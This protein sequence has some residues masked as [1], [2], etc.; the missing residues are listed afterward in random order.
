MTR[1][2]GAIAVGG[3]ALL[4]LGDTHA[5]SAAEVTIQNETVR[6][7]YE[8]DAGL[9]TLTDLKTGKAFAQQGSLADAHGPAKVAA[10]TD[11]TFGDGQAI[12]V[13]GTDGAQA[14]L[15]VFPKL[16]FALVRGTMRNGGGDAKVLNKVPL[17]TLHLN[18]GKPADQLK[19]FG[20]GG[21]SLPAKNPGSYAWQV[22]AEP[23]S[24]NGVVSAWLTHDR[25]TGVL[26]TPVSNDQVT[27][28]ARGEYG[29]LRLE[30]GSSTD[31]ETLAIGYFDD[32]RLGLESWADAVAKVYSIHLPVQPTGYCTW[33][34]DKHGGAGD[35][36]S[37]AE[38][39]E[40]A[41]KTLKPYG[42]SFVQIDDGWQL[43]NSQGNGPKKNFT[44]HNPKGP[45]PSGMKAAA[46]HIRGLG[47]TAGIWFMPFA[48][49]FNDPW[50]KDHQD[51]FVKNKDGKPY[52]SS[53]GGTSMDMTHPGA[54]EY[55]RTYVRRIT[56]E[57]GYRYIKIDGLYTGT[58]NQQIYVNSGYKEDSLGDAVFAN[59][60]KTNIEAFR[61][62]LKLVREAAGRETFILGCCAPQNMR[63]YAGA[64][65]L[66][67]AMRIGPDNG[68]SWKG[69]FGPSPVFGTR[70][71]FLNGRV[72]YCDPDPGYA[73]ASISL[74][75]VK[76][77]FS[78]MA[79]AGQLNT[80]SDWIPGLTAERLDVMKRTM[81]SHGLP[82]RPVDLF[83]NEPARIWLLTDDRHWPRRDVIALFNWSN[84]DANVD[85]SLERIGLP[86]NVEYVG[87]DFWANELVS[88]IKGQLKCTMPG[89]SCRVLAVR[90]VADHPQLI[91]TSRHVTQGIVDVLEETWD[92]SSSMLSGR[93]K[94]VGADAYELRL[95]TAGKG[96]K[97]GVESVEVSPEDKAAGVTI[98]IKQSGDLARVTIQSPAS[99]EVMWRVRFKKTA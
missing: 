38:L 99:R 61:D 93:S 7:S 68:G 1:V 87:F 28:Q 62:G 56:Q 48:G 82:A 97:W 66:V 80:S 94:V 3:M 96:A 31:T 10:V 50:F 79:I 65:G 64:F 29:R 21:L 60:N 84:T 45:Y 5:V 77:I 13:A 73:R 44:A 22:V 43:G 14:K 85:Y 26:F 23:V 30:G 90:P 8:S 52:D 32:A 42:F 72:W 78:W 98:D 86:R 24:R 92:A 81:P 57:W 25:A 70:N 20:T 88:G 89:A 76:L 54:R 9:F 37:L 55:L 6:V 4:A 2:A 63:S 47:M 33:Y 35:E 83:E 18:L 46:D 15:M 91:S 34:S 53:W 36:K 59:P 71:Y 51:W 19:A 49:T 75:Q 39:V 17:A 16:P 11:R 41:A 27:L 69:W 74:Q 58:G 12:E 67:D 40:F 95:V